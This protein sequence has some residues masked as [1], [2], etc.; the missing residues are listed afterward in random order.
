[1]PFEDKKR[2]KFKEIK[3][4]TKTCPKCGHKFNA[5]NPKTGKKVQVCPKCG[6]TFIELH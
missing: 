1:M 2:I 6:H 4:V 5:Y 3:K